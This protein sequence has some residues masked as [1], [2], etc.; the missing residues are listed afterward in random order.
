[1]T[2]I[3]IIS[4]TSLAALLVIWFIW[5]RDREKI[6]ITT[7]YYPPDDLDPMQIE[8]IASGDISSSSMYA[9]ILYWIS[10]GDLKK[11]EK[12]SRAGAERISDI[13]ADQPAHARRL[14]TR[15]FGRRSRIWF[16]KM[17]DDWNLSTM[18]LR[19]TR[20]SLQEMKVFESRKAAFESVYVL[21][22]FLW[23]FILLWMFRYNV[24]ILLILFLIGMSIWIMRNILVYHFRLTQSWVTVILAVGFMMLG[25]GIILQQSIHLD[26]QIIDIASLELL[27]FAGIYLC[28]IME[29]RLNAVLYGRVLGFREFLKSAEIDKLRELSAIDPAY[30][31]EILPYVVVFGMGTE[32]SDLW[33]VEATAKLP[34]RN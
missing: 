31:E 7:E 17:P 2:V 22:M 5:G 6:T 8:Y 3:T 19:E 23:L 24:V 9:M 13:P 1:M 11:V 34:K 33:E 32:W 26:L 18:L 10:K 27:Y 12:D 21:Y 4:V 15:L 30:G 25:A 14:F 16:D 20:K 29:Q 28:A